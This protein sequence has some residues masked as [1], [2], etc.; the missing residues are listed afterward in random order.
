MMD[1]YRNIEKEQVQF[2]F[3][4]TSENVE[5]HFFYNEILKMGGSIYEIMSW[6]KIGVISYFRQW[7]A[8]IKKE[9]YDIMHTHMGPESGIPLFF[10]WLNGITKRIVHARDSGIYD[11]SF[12]KKCYL[13]IVK[14]MTGIFATDR[15]YCSMEAAIYAFGKKSLKKKRTFFLPNAIDLNV[16]KAIS[17]NK[18]QEIVEHLNL[19]EYKYIIGTVGNGRTVK[20]HIFLVKIFREFLK[21]TPESALLIIGDHTQ[22]EEAKKYVK[23]NGIEKNVKFLGVR[24]DISEILQTMDLFVLPSLSEGAPGSVI[25]AQA[26]NIPCIL[27]DSITR[28]VDV[29]TGLLKYISLNSPSKIWVEQMLESCQMKRPAQSVT[30]L[31]LH[32][33]GYDI[34]NS[35]KRLLDIYKS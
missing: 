8:I 15:I 29:G 25:E 33:S 30:I 16:F 32:E 20:N 4:V 21:F 31:K 17:E 34:T 1:I 12:K 14:A 26:A 7:K 19:T 2:D 11:A 6:R 9:N 24:T 13:K 23:E 10:G 18:R 27:S 5:Q 22:D 28:S 35:S 3:A